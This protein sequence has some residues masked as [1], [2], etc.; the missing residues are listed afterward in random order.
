[1]RLGGKAC[2]STWGKGPQWEVM[3]AGMPVFSA[4]LHRTTPGALDAGMVALAHSR[5]N[6]VVSAAVTAAI[7]SAEEEDAPEAAGTPRYVARCTR[8]PA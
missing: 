4:D 2:S 6:Q 3:K 5:A 1:M 7:R 8:P